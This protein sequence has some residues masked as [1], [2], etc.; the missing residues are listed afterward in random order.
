MPSALGHISPR[1]KILFLAIFFI[2]LPGAVL[3]Y[4]GF[5]SVSDKADTLTTTY[6]GTLDLVRVRIE[7]ELL[8]QEDALRSSLGA[9]ELKSGSF[10]ETKAWLRDIELA[11]PGLDRFFL[12]N[13]RGGVMSSIVSLGWATGD[14]VSETAEIARVTDFEA[15][16][17]AEFVKKDLGAA[18][19]SYRSLLARARTP[20]GRQLVLARIGRCY[21]KMQRYTRGITEYRK[22]LA[23]ADHEPGSPFIPFEVVALS[24]I[25]DGYASL[26]DEKKRTSALVALEKRLLDHPWDLGGGDYEYYLKSTISEVDSQLR[27][28]AARLL[29][30]QEVA[31]LMSQE[32]RALAACEFVR[33]VHQTIAPQVIQEL[34]REVVAEP[35][36]IR[37]PLSLNGSTID[38]SCLRLGSV[39]QQHG[40][41]ALGFAEDEE[42]FVSTLLPR[43]LDGVD[44]GKDIVVGILDPQGIPRY[45]QS[46]A[47]STRY[48]M[49]ENFSKMHSAWKV[50]LFHSQG[51]SVGELVGREKG[52]YLAL[53][54]G[55]AGVMVIGIVVVGR[56]A[57]HEV[58]VSR[59]KS[60]FVSSVSHELKTPLALI[61]MFGETLESGIVSDE[62]KRHEFYRIITKESERLTHLINN[63]LD[64]SKMEAGNKRY[65]LEEADV[66]QVIRS[67]LEAY[68][69]HIR[70]LGFEMVTALPDEPIVMRIDKDAISQALLNLLNN[71]AKYSEDHKYLRVEVGK[72]GEAVFI[73]VEDR[74]VGIPREELKKIFDKF[75][76]ASTTRTKETTGS[77]LGLTLV[78]HIAEAHGGSVEV[79]STVGK[80]SRFVLDLPLRGV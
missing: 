41:V 71:A 34:S 44:L 39:F 17:T 73:A 37:I 12:V 30:E 78:R 16:E 9:G 28:P 23:L 49:A 63:V 74:G 29:S 1:T 14:Q 66:V 65:R 42:Y 20:L 72:K 67:T 7:T 32:H 2:L 36:P 55:I 13:A 80:G 50:A 47:P 58:E 6:R 18:V 43:V 35:V 27:S 22:I 48:L 46:H 4:L 52:I 40:I 11:H 26:R 79:S 10:R 60:E 64:F 33:R 75:Y 62:A 70:D 69:F 51:K 59:L 76:R 3:S 15:A 53:F 45:L 24:Q 38:E 56:A 57:L 8:R 68:R 5:R 77:G 25:A 31:A 61:R 19:R 21:F 54:L